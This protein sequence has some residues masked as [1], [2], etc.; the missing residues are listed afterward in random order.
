VKPAPVPASTR[1]GARGWIAPAALVAVW[2]ALAAGCRDAPA[3]AY[4]A[5]ADP[6]SVFAADIEP[7]LARRCEGCHFA[8]GAQYAT[9]PFDDARTVLRLGDAMLSQFDRA[10]DTVRVRAYLRL[11]ST[12]EAP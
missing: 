10:E 4:P 5:G 2:G 1:P 6:D 11:A 7:L 8:G 9:M 3:V 12:P